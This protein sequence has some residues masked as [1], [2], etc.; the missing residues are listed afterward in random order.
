MLLFSEH[1][2]EWGFDIPEPVFSH[3][4]KRCLA[5]DITN[6]YDMYYWHEM[7]RMACPYFGKES[8]EYEKF[9]RWLEKW[10]PGDCYS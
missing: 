5:L 9:F 6:T 3:V 1:P 7:A 4:R 2:H 10:I 8:E